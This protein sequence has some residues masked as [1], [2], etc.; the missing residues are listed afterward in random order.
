MIRIAFRCVLHRCKSQDIRCQKLFLFSIKYVKA[1]LTIVEDKTGKVDYNYSL[2][3]PLPN[4]FN[5]AQVLISESPLRET[6]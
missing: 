2:S 4:T 6:Q 5:S 1:K 3:F